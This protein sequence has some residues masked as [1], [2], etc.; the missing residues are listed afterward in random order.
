MGLQI[1]MSIHQQDD[2]AFDDLAK[3]NDDLMADFHGGF[4]ELYSEFVGEPN[5]EGP[6]K[7]E[8]DKLKIA[9]NWDSEFAGYGRNSYGE[10]HNS[11]MVWGCYGDS[12]FEIISQHLTAG[13]L[14]FFI[15]IEGND[16]EYRIV[17]PGAVEEKNASTIRF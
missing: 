2:I 7:M 14:V 13:K 16:N 5:W 10:E 15:E 12:V 4:G 6:F 9:E 17:T 1:I 8:G 3:M 11:T